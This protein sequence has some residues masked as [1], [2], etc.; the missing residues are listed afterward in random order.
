MA[1]ANKLCVLPGLEL[2]LV[3]IQLKIILACH[4]ETSFYVRTLRSWIKISSTRTLSDLRRKDTN[5]KT[6][7]EPDDFNHLNDSASG[8]TLELPV[9]RTGFFGVIL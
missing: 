7:T 3:L 9:L 4:A 6:L 2:G 8:P 5:R 1:T